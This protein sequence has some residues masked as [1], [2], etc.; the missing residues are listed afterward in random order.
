MRSSTEFARAVPSIL[1]GRTFLPVGLAILGAALGAL[2]PEAA[3]GRMTGASFGS[4]PLFL[5]ENRGQL[6]PDVLA[7]E[8]GAGHLTL[9]QADGMTIYFRN[10]PI[11]RAN[12]SGAF[13]ALELQAALETLPAA[14]IE[15]LE[16]RWGGGGTGRTPTLEEPLSTR[17][18]FLRAERSRS[19]SATAHARIRYPEVHDGL[20]LVAYGN[21]RLLE[22]DWIVRPGADPRKAEIEIRGAREVRV[23]EDGELEMILPSGRTIR[24]KKPFLYQLQ[25]ESREAVAGEFEVRQAVPN[26]RYGFRVGRYDPTR[27][28]ILD[29]ILDYSSY[30]GGLLDEISND[31]A[32]DAM[33]SGY[34]TG[35]TVSTD[36]PTYWPY[37]GNHAGGGQDVFVMK[38]SSDGSSVEYATYLGGS[39]L[40]VGLAIEVDRFGQAYVAG[41]TSSPDFP[42][43]QAVQTGPSGSLDAFAFVL[44][45]DGDELLWS[46]YLGG[47]GTDLALGLAVGLDG[48]VVLVGQTNSTNFPR[49]A[50]I[51]SEL[52]G[53]FDAWIARLAP[54][55]GTLVFSTYFG[56][57][58]NDFAHGVARSAVDR[59]YV[60]GV[61]DSP[62]L[63]VLQPIQGQLAG[64]QDA[65]L[66]LLE[67]GSHTVLTSTYLGGSGTDLAYA[68][69]VDDEGR[70][71]LAGTTNSQDFPVAQAYQPQL[72]GGW[73]GFITRLDLSARSIAQS[74]YLGGTA[75]D[76]IYGVGLD[77][78]GYVYVAGYTGSNDFPQVEPF[79]EGF[80]GAFDGFLTRLLPHGT[81]VDFSTYLGGVGQDYGKSLAVCYCGLAL[82]AGETDSPDL[83]TQNPVFGAL[84][85]GLDGYISRF[86]DPSALFCDDFESGTTSRWASTEPGS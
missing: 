17:T 65:F 34:L 53:G 69:A 33:G 7:Y 57:S 12:D 75:F 54:G 41:M 62:D 2:A 4:V 16:L 45:A 64:G 21:Q 6:P 83:P 43:H 84:S 60:I 80:G 70:P 20:D 59:L 77:R 36:F 13:S 35:L 86:R 50:P 51:Q 73:D 55:G 66:I 1:H 48:G 47:S 49:V 38:I 67:G 23:N 11:P 9:F 19:V 26:P 28:L 52:A 5:V 32:V 30:F 81:G 29:P 85:G 22:Y 44:S 37:Q 10:R 46:T 39:G 79:Q 56:G 78:S 40:D 14:E 82:V 24:Q 63:T 27:E 61:T 25:G 15:S 18:H 72:A 42:T 74:T 8:Q 76:G 68:V 31:V 58:G 3:A 71:V